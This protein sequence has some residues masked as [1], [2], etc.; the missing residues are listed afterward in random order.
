VQTAARSHPGLDPAPSKRH[1]TGTA[2]YDDAA[3]RAWQGQRFGAGL[4][5]GE[6]CL[7]AESDTGSFCH[8]DVPGMADICLASVIAMMRV[9]KSPPAARRRSAA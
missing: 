9:F 3:W 5:A 6:Q 7:A 2:G 4:A 8:G 1:S